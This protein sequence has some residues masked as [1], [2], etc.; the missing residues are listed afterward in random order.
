[1]LCNFLRCALL[2][3]TCTTSLL[4]VACAQTIPTLDTH[5]EAVDAS[6]QPWSAIGKLYNETGSACTAVAIERDKVL[7]AAHC[8]FNYRTR[9]FVSATALHFLAG[10]YIGQF[11]AHARVTSYEIGAGFNALNYG[12]TSTADWAILNLTENLPAKIE[13]IKLRGT[14]SPNGTKAI[15]AGYP[16]DRAYAMTADTDCELGDAVDDGKLVLHTCRGIRGY[17]GAPILVSSA[18]HKLE[19]A[20]IQIATIQGYGM[21]GML[22]VPSRTIEQARFD[23]D[24]TPSDLYGINN[25]AG[26]LS[27]L[28]PFV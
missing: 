15:L 1:M 26:D 24:Q 16:Q 12:E 5:R 14:A 18:D 9:Q 23:E 10:Y 4:A 8:I 6:Q 22:A 28:N 27:A 25:M 11:I 20:G 2:L 7:T 19:I 21:Q 13:P 17:S 3:A